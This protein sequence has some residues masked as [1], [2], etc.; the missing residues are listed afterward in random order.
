MKNSKR[1]GYR[2]NLST[3]PR[4]RN[5]SLLPPTALAVISGERYGAGFGI[6][7]CAMSASVV[8]AMRTVSEIRVRPD[9]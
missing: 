3:K 6:G 4:R 2:E 9:M 8:V 5:R 1:N 7:A